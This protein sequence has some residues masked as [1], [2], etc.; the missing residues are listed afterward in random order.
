MSAQAA[1]VLGLGLPPP[2]LSTLPNASAATSPG[3]TLFFSGWVIWPIF[4]AGV[5]CANRASTL[6]S[7][8]WLFMVSLLDGVGN[9]SRPKGAAW[10]DQGPGRAS[11]RTRGTTS[12]SRATWCTVPGKPSGRSTTS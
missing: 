2:P 12:P 6:D 3:R 9:G 8:S 4:S 10:D 7:I 1:G 11:R 5:I